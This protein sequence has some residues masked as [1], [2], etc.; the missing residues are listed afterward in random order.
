MRADPFPSVLLAPFV[1]LIETEVPNRQ[2]LSCFLEYQ[3]S[4]LESRDSGQC[5][6]ILR[7]EHLFPI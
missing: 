7:S 1:I 4:M 5:V 3:T 2:G 6:E